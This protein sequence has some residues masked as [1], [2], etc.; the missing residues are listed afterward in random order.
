MVG[1]QRL[2][3]PMH[4]GHIGDEV[5]GEGAVVVLGDSD[6]VYPHL[7]RYGMLLDVVV[8]G[9][10]EEGYFAPSERLVWCGERATVSCLHLHKVVVAIG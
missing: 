1:R 5:G 9:L 6:E 4:T 7:G 2:F 10:D 8:G 3:L